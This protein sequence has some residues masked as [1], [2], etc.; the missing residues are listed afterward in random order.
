MAMPPAQAVCSSNVA[1]AVALG[2]LVSTLALA[3]VA[4]PQAPAA[5]H[6]PQHKCTSRHLLCLHFVH[7]HHIVGDATRHADACRALGCRAQS[8]SVANDAVAP[9]HMADQVCHALLRAMRDAREG[10]GWDGVDLDLE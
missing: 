8:S 5:G 10:G 7:E 1:A 9:P 6:H 4:R 2:A 3:V